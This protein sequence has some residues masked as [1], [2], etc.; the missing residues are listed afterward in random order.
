MKQPQIRK[1]HRTVGIF[2]A[3]FL[4]ITALGGAILL[5]RR[6]GWLDFETA[7]TIRSIHNWEVVYNYVGLVVALGLLGMAI[8]GSVIFFMIRKATHKSKTIT[9]TTRP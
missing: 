8:S 5:F 1:I 7:A 2:L 9:T 3:P 4:M 6:I